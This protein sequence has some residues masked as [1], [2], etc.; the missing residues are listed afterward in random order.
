MSD[1]DHAAEPHETILLEPGITGFEA[2]PKDRI[3]V[4]IFDTAGGTIFH[5]AATD[6]H[7]E[8]LPPKEKK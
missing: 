7:I 1:R 6:V 4:R 5:G 8:V 2:G 3:Y